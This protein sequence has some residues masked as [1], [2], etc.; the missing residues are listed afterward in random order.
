M[1]ERRSRV[2]GS[3][4]WYSS[5]IPMLRLGRLIRLPLAR[6]LTHL[7][8]CSRSR[9]LC[10]WFFNLSGGCPTQAVFAWVSLAIQKRAPTIFR[11]RPGVFFGLADRQFG[12]VV[13]DPVKILLA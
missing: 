3:I 2:S 10:S 7:F 13:D 11:C 4:V 1:C 5:S 12:N 6:S 8:G 9:F